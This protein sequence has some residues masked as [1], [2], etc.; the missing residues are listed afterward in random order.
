MQLDDLNAIAEKEKAAAK[1]VCLRVCMS[2]G[3]MS[4]QA[5]VTKKNLDAAVKAK[6]RKRKSK[7]AAWVAWLLRSR[8][9]RGVDHQHGE[10]ELLNL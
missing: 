6:A 3:C 2:A 7:C 10:E 9:T 5:D 8:P 4:S 1:K